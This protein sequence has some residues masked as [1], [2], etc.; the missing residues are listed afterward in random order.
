LSFGEVARIFVRVKIAVG[1]FMHT[2]WQMH[3]QR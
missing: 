2:P 3:I 1:A